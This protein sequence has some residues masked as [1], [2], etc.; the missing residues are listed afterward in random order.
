VAR[1]RQTHT[2]GRDQYTF[3]LGYARTKCN[4]L[5]HAHLLNVDFAGEAEFDPGGVMIAAN[6]CVPNV[7]ACARNH[8]HLAGDNK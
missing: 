4:E 1:D 6:I 5:K 3:H 8:Q 7:H 2:D